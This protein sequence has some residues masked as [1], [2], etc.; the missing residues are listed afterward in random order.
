M[1]R[2]EASES[3]FVEHPNR[4]F[5]VALAAIAGYVDAFGFLVLFGAFVGHMSGNVVAGVAQLGSG[6]GLVTYERLLAIPAFVLGV[7]LAYTLIEAFRRRASRRETS[8]VLLLEA[9]L[10]VVFAVM[11]ALFSDEAGYRP[12]TWRLYILTVAAAMAMGVQTGNLRRVEGVPL[13]TTFISG[14]LTALTV[15]AVGNLFAR[16]DLKRDPASAKAAERSRTTGHA[17]A[18]VAPCL[19]VFV[20]GAF[21]AAILEARTTGPAKFA[22]VA[23]AIAAL[24]LL[25]YLMRDEAA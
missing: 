19:G 3:W 15:N 20:V 16:L 6:L 8:V 13:H 11:G 18:V 10:L 24:A 21:L 7:A 12:D 17:V 4:W 2:T 14:A 22:V 1:A 9:S 5:A 25:A 23:P